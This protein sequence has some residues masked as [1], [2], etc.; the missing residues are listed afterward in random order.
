MRKCL[1]LAV[2]LAVLPL[3]AVAQDKT[4]KKADEQPAPVVVKSQLPKG[5]KALGLSDQQKKNVYVL[6][7]KYAAKRQALEEQL[8]AL[9]DEETKA[10]EGV[11]TEGQKAR[12]KE[13]KK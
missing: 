4:T 12:L 1:S 8:K 7:A 9:K 6:R 13:V 5:W 2:L 10:L 11:L 3:W